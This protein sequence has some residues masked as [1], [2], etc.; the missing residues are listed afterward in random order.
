MGI[1][2]ENANST[3]SIGGTLPSGAARVYISEM[4]QELCLVAKQGGHDDI[5]VLLKL[6][7]HAIIEISAP[8]TD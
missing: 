7:R 5:L 3:T 8:S 1:K 6:M 4:L 2:S